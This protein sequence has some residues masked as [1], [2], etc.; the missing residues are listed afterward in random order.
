[1]APLVILFCLL[2]SACSST[3]YQ[4]QIADARTCKVWKGSNEDL[5]VAEVG[6]KEAK[7]TFACSAFSKCREAYAH[8]ENNFILSGV[9]DPRESR[10]ESLLGTFENQ[11]LKL[12]KLLF[13]PI[14]VKDGRAEISIN[15]QLNEEIKFNQACSPRQAALGVALIV[16]GHEQP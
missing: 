6:E 13:G 12:R 5:I 15:E 7:R 11:W 9:K 10:F 8:Y 14:L 2:L 16:E 4:Q 3:P 1:M